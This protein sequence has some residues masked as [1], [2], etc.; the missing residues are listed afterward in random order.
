MYYKTKFDLTVFISLS[1]VN[2]IVD[3]STEAVPTMKL[4]NFKVSCQGILRHHQKVPGKAKQSAP[5]YFI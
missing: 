2:D 4:N 5:K 1:H 3:E